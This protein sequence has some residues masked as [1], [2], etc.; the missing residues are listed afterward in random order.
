MLPT[1]ENG[2]PG[3][4]LRLVSR[5]DFARLMGAAIESALVRTGGIEPERARS[6]R[7][8]AL[9]RFSA[10]LR[11]GARRVR[12]L[13]KTE[14]LAELEREH[15]KLLR[16]R[17]VWT[18]E[19]TEL[20]RELAEVRA[21]STTRVL[22]ASEQELLGQALEADVR[23]LLRA[24]ASAV[25]LSALLA[26][27]AGRR[28]RALTT[29]Q[30]RERERID[31]LERRVAKLCAEIQRMEGRLAELARRAEI[32]P[33]LPSVYRTVQGL[34]QAAPQSAAKAAMLTRIFEQNLALQRERA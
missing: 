12:A 24:G 32:D 31:L 34:D 16:R 13:T 23:E 20:E 30:A 8:D 28:E 19:L 33:G 2:R 11:E 4:W 1:L 21:G 26:R 10:R 22:T 18:A 9:A 14:H 27:E 17:Q 7:R 25:A 3:R 15:G 6:L 29:V 5:A